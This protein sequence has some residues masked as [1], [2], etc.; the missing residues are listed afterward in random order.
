M[1]T[2]E[3]ANKRGQRTRAAFGTIP[4]KKVAI[5]ARPM[6]DK[7]IGKDGMFVTQGVPQLR[8]AA[9]GRA[10]AVRVADDQE[11]EGITEHPFSGPACGAQAGWIIRPTD[12]FERRTTFDRLSRKSSTS[13]TPRKRGR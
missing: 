3:R 9:G 1:V 7:Y 2:I 10:A 6:D 11:G 5:N 8:R 13:A 4:L 12:S